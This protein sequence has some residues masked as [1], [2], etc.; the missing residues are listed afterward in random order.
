MPLLRSLPPPPL[1]NSLIRQTHSNGKQCVAAKLEKNTNKLNDGHR[2]KQTLRMRKSFIPVSLLFK[3]KFQPSQRNVSVS[4]WMRDWVQTRRAKEILARQ[5]HFNIK[6]STWWKASKVNII[7]IRKKDQS[8][9]LF[10]EFQKKGIL[11]IEW[12]KKIIIEYSGPTC[13]SWANCLN[14]LIS[15]QSQS[16]YANIVGSS[17]NI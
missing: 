12:K 5:K 6:C 16:T 17:A 10:K 15:T 4:Y 1:P 7:K 14:M 11:Y 13:F 8:G 3:K 9:C 2:F